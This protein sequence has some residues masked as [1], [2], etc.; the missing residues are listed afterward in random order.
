LTREIF[1]SDIPWITIYIH[2]GVLLFEDLVKEVK[3]I[4][5]ELKTKAPQTIAGLL[6]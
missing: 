2:C 6:Y 3:Y 1:L 5:V 4:S